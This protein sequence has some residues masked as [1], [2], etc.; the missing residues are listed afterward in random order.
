MSLADTLLAEFDNETALTRRAL[1]RAPGTAFGWRPHAKSFTLG[2]LCTHIGRLPHWGTQILTHESYDVVRDATPRA[3][4]AATPAEAL[5]LF[6]GHVAE[7][8]TRLTSM[9]DVELSAVWSLKRNGTVLMSTP[10]LA[11]FKQYTLNHLIHHRGQLTVY[12]RLQDVPV[13][14]LYG[15]TADEAL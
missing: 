6:D 5:A 7:A 1:E 4:A 2:E 9:A 14:P 13:P 3:D 8:R 15:P 10:R 11:A 12:L